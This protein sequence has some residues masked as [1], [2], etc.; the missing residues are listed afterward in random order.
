ML[1]RRLIDAHSKKV[2]ADV[3]ITFHIFLNKKRF[4]ENDAGKF[5]KS[6][7]DC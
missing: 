3:Q 7:P 2:L 6:S 4:S 5:N 1:S